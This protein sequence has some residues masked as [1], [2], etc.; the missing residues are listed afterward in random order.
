MVAKGDN[1]SITMELFKAIQYFLS[2][3]PYRGM[4]QYI[5]QTSKVTVKDFNSSKISKCFWLD[6]QNCKRDR[7]IN[8]Q[9]I[10]ELFG[11]ISQESTAVLHANMVEQIRLDPLY[12]KCIGHVIMGFKNVNLKQ[13][14]DV[15]SR[16]MTSTDELAIFALSKI[17]Q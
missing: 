8:K 2:K 5:H 13:W 16:Q 7:K 4:F 3:Y 1:G 14:C 9:C 6:T 12:Y 17:Y 10:F 11:A 15:M